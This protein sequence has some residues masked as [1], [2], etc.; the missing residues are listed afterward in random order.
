MKTGQK[1][2]WGLGMLALLL[3]AVFLLKRNAVP[4]TAESPAAP[5]PAAT[6]APTEPSAAPALAAT[7][8]A[9]HGAA[10]GEWTMD[11]DAA[12]ALAAETG[13]PL[14]LNFTASDWSGRSRW[15]ASQVFAQEAWQRYAK[16]HLV[17]VW[18]DFPRDKSRVPEAFAERNAQ[19][20]RKF[21]IG[22]FPTFILLDS[23]G[24]TRLGQTGAA[25]DATPESFIA[26]LEDLL[27]ASD[28]SV[29]ALKATM[30]D[31]QQAELDAANEAR[32]IARQKLDDLIRTDPDQ[33]EENASQYQAARE[34]IA[35]AES[36]FLQLLKAAK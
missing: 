16:D 34:E 27:L 21:E 31:A 19:L 7:Q 36:A 28:K 35:N 6:P 18:I 24:Q 1:F 32:T 3:A 14:L 2:I 10:L 33:T 25:R 9:I 22:E 13:K 5:S 15:M 20:S 4:P 11:L 23:D 29:A 30:T 26:I 12:Q 17:L 8:A